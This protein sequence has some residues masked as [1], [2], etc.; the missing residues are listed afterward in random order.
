MSLRVPI[1]GRLGATPETRKLLDINSKDFDDIVRHFGRRISQ[2]GVMANEYKAP[3][4]NGHV[5]TPTNLDKTAY[6]HAS[7]TEIIAQQR[8]FVARIPPLAKGIV[9]SWALF[10]FTWLLLSLFGMV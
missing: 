3:R 9:V 5:I 1:T 2:L 4:V 8:S 7:A 6:P 10:N